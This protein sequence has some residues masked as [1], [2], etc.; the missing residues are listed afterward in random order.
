MFQRSIFQ[1]NTVLLE[2]IQRK[3]KRSAIEILLQ[4]YFKSEWKYTFEIT[5]TNFIFIQAAIP[6]LH[7]I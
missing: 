5:F 7:F 3:Q 4:K 1:G 2:I 6:F